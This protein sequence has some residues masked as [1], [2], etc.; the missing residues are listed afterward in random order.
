MRCPSCGNKSKPRP[1]A[2]EELG[3]TSQG[4]K[5]K[6]SACGAL[7]VN[8]LMAGT[9]LL[10][11]SATGNTAE[12][13]AQMVGDA[14]LEM[15]AN[16]VR[17]QDVPWVPDE[18]TST[19]LT[20]L[21]LDELELKLP[22]LTAVG[23]QNLDCLIR[24][25]ERSEVHD[26]VKLYEQFELTRE[27][28]ANR[29]TDEL[30]IVRCASCGALASIHDI[31]SFGVLGTVLGEGESLW[32]FRCDGVSEVHFN[33]GFE[34]KGSSP[35][36]FA[37]TPGAARASGNASRGQGVRR[38]PALE[39]ARLSLES[40]VDAPA[41]VDSYLRDDWVNSAGWAL[42]FFAL[43]MRLSRNEVSPA[44][45]SMAQMLENDTE[46]SVS[47]LDAAAEAVH[48]VHVLRAWDHR[49]KSRFDPGPLGSDWPERAAGL[50]ADSARS[51]VGEDGLFEGE[52]EALGSFILGG[53]G[54]L[55]RGPASERES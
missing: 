15:A 43:A 22:T 26:Q 42:G 1:P 7:I 50:V 53:Y 3:K 24:Y 6:C 41:A 9:R 12:Q 55:L 49:G 40:P 29:A 23:L 25:L 46:A 30:D 44:A 51:E 27:E 47:M 35:A 34:P 38:L 21:R 33:F 39:E 4:K 5:F 19:D 31:D 45:S 10:D 16:R 18:V 37:P 11:E 14:L 48:G 54:M 28:M 36:G 52:V 32:C 13:N 17:H 2:F 8:S 20:A